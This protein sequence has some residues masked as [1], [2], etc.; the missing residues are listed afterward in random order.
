MV[1]IFSSDIRAY[2]PVSVVFLGHQQCMGGIDED[3]CEMLE[4][5]E[6]EDDEYR[7]A[8][9]MCIPEQ[10]WLDGQYDCMDWTDEPGSITVMTDTC[11]NNPSIMCDEH[12]CIYQQWSCGDGEFSLF[13]CSM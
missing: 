3:Y 6:C 1:T 10:Y 13:S 7:Y 8:N 12:L 11:F 4:F 9:G 2:C 5:N